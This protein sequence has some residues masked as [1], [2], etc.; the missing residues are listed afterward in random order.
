MSA[1]IMRDLKVPD[2]MAIVRYDDIPMAAMSKVAAVL[3]L[4][5]GERVMSHQQVQEYTSTH[6]GIRSQKCYPLISLGSCG[7]LMAALSVRAVVAARRPDCA[8]R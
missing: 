6:L 3:E 4:V 8:S 2:D 1:A 7:C 5:S